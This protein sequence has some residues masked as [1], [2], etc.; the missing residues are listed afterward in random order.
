[1]TA[2]SRMGNLAPGLLRATQPLPGKVVAQRPVT[3]PPAAQDPATSAPD[4]HLPA[5]AQG[6]QNLQVT[7]GHVGLELSYES[8]QSDGQS[9][10][11]RGE[12][13]KLDFSFL[14]AVAGSNVDGAEKNVDPKVL[15]GF[16]DSTAQLDF[17]D[18]ATL[19][20]YDSA[21]H[22][23]FSE[24]EQQLHLGDTGLDHVEAVFKN[25]VADFFGRVQED[26]KADTAAPQPLR[27][28]L[29][30][31]MGKLLQAGGDAPNAAKL[32]DQSLR[33]NSQQPAVRD[34]LSALRDL[35]AKL[36]Q[37]DANATDLLAA[38]QFAPAA[39]GDGTFSNL[40]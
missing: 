30:G 17:T 27:G 6:G 5:A 31:E 13:L 11:Y 14:R 29:F 15:Q 8:L 10:S 18:N 28:H 9:T 34:W 12:F 3:P 37:G 20:Q 19:D 23:L 7:A 22:A 4:A 25:A 32:Y 2:L 36:K 16:I 39:Q 1:M 40:I 33:Q 21:T 26:G 24:L 38:A 35:V